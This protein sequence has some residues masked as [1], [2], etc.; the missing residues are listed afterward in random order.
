MSHRIFIILVFSFLTACL[1]V[2]KRDSKQIFQAFKH[3]EIQAERML[4]EIIKQKD[5]VSELP[6]ENSPA[7]C[8]RSLNEDGSLKLIPSRDWCSGFFPGELW[9]LYEF[10]KDI[11]WKEQA[12]K[13]T[14]FIEHEKFNTEDHDMGFRMMCS[15]G[16]G[17][18]LTRNA[19]YREILIQSANSLITRFNE[20]VGCIR[21]WDTERW[22]YPVII[23]NMMNL[24]LLFW[25][26]KETGDPVYYN[27]AVKH[28]NT[29]L[30]NH[31]REDNSS[32]HLVIYDTVTGEVLEKHT[33]K[34]LSD[35]SALARGQAWGLYGYTVAYRETGYGIYFR[36]AEKIAEFILSHSD[37]P[38]DMIPFWDFNAPE[39][40]NEPRDVSAAAITASAL[41]E[42]STLGPEKK[43]GY[44][45][46]ADQ[47]MKQ[48]YEKYRSEEGENRGFVLTNS[49]ADKIKSSELSVPLICAD[50]YYME[51]LSR[52]YKFL[53]R[54]NTQKHD[55]LLP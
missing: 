53:Q 28:A 43:V 8:P 11:K 37:L 51:A 13:Y 50:Y 16:K 31:F 38:E 2:L 27:I 6:G 3:T 39:I 41:Y 17:N 55:N 26:S 40:P 52:K 4:E 22:Q 33:G 32:Y 42:L 5:Q 49:I 48:L 24:E 19:A 30:E 9:L 1:P 18:E 23:D 7:V 29:T 25:A 34:G 45:H 46:A 44:S 20:N 36:K 12:E 54:A 14:G 15:F 47:I 35:E 10:T 21:S